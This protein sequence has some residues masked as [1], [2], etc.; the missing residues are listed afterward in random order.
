MN[1]NQIN[2]EN[3]LVVAT[4]RKNGFFLLFLL[5]ISLPGQYF[6]AAILGLVFLCGSEGTGCPSWTTFPFLIIILMLSIIFAWLLIKSSKKVVN[7]V[8]YLFFGF[9]IIYSVYWLGMNVWAYANRGKVD[10]K[11]RKMHEEEQ[12]QEFQLPSQDVP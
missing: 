11:I 6:F 12:Q 9:F 8:C 1:T 3:Q 2:S 7:I 10:E 4:N 5:L